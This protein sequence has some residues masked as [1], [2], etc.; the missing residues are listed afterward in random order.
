VWLKGSVH[1]QRLAVAEDLAAA[2]PHGQLGPRRRK[3]FVLEDHDAG[4]GV[5]AA[6]VEVGD[7]RGQVGDRDHALRT[8]LGGHRHGAAIGNEAAIALDVDDEGVE[9]GG[10]DEIE[11]RAAEHAAADAI[12]R[13]VDGFG[14]KRHQGDLGGRAGAAVHAGPEIAGSAREHL[15]GRNVVADK[16]A[17]RARPSLAAVRDH[18]GVGNRSAGLRVDDAK[19]IGSCGETDGRGRE[20]AGE[21]E[22]DTGLA[23]HLGYSLV[24]VRNVSR[25]PVSVTRKRGRAI[26]SSRRSSVNAAR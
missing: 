18:D 21:H 5:D 25:Q 10:G 12:H 14:A 22:R 19:P 8:D 4:D 15:T 11:R 9:L 24:N 16:S 6:C 7:E 20:Q 13:Q 3:Q 23:S 2:S 26:G 1:A 17:V